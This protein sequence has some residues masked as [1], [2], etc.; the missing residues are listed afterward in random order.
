MSC[1]SQLL[2]LFREEEVLLKPDKN[3][4]E[5]TII[6]CFPLYFLLYKVLKAL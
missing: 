5:Q 4:K 3:A 6:F 1:H 2:I